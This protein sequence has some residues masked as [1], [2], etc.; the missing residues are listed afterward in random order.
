MLLSFHT[1][2]LE[3]LCNDQK[4][5]VRN[6]GAEQAQLIARRITQLEAADCLEIMR[7]LPQVRAHELK[8]NRAGQGA[9]R[10]RAK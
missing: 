5:L 4:A 7:S 9:A 2:K 6:Y 3:K 1:R 8:G 10:P